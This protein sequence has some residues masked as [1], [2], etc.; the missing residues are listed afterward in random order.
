MS[1]VSD[2]QP[3]QIQTPV[4]PIV[5]NDDLGIITKELDANKLGSPRIPKRFKQCVLHIGT[6]K[7]GSSAFQYFCTIN[8]KKLRRDGIFYPSLGTS[9]SQWEI[10]AATHDAPWSNVDLKQTFQIKDEADRVRFAA[11]LQHQLQ[12][13]FKSDNG[14]DTLLISSEHMHSRLQSPQALNRL[15]S[16]LDQWADAFTIVVFFRRQD[17][18][19]I[20]LRSTKVKSDSRNDNAVFPSGGGNSL[21]Y[22]NYDDI[23][24]LWASVFGSDCME[25]RVY[26]E[27]L[28][29]PNGIIDELADLLNID[30]SNKKL[31]KQAI[32][33]SL[34]R[35]AFY[36]LEELNAQLPRFVDGR[37]DPLREGIM[38]DLS[39]LF[40]GKHYPARRADAEEF[41]ARFA[42]RNERLRQ[43]AFPNRSA[44]LFDDDFSEYPKDPDRVGISAKEAVSIAVALAQHAR[45]RHLHDRSITVLLRRLLRI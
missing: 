15:K 40:P 39:E 23:Y 6:E 37:K 16:I 12:S 10:V 18:V 38:L 2:N 31:P 19:A 11:S 9:G 42:E 26:K 5:D 20:S 3:A 25:P 34:S 14:C 8:R 1:S 22:F 41:C 30:L 28:S 4:C 7:T 43:L 29:T 44:P 24:E 45:E 33:P 21:R 35:P 13:E 17:R 32:N 27:K 36:F